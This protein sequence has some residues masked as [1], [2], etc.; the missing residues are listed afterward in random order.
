VNGKGRRIKGQAA[1]RELAGMLTDWLGECVQRRLGQERDGGGDIVIGNYSIQ[2]KRQEVIRIDDWWAQA[3]RDSGNLIPVLAYRRS[4]NPW[5][6]VIGIDEF[7]R[8]LRESIDKTQ[9]KA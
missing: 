6:V 7:V 9:D 4:R 1:E 3:E 2:V 8:L 5:K